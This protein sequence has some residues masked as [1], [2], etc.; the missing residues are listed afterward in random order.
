MSLLKS[1]RFLQTPQLRQQLMLGFL[2]LRI[3]VDA[4]HGAYDD[5]LRFVEVTYAFCAARWVD[6]VDALAHADSLVGTRRLADIA[7][8]AEFVDLQRHVSAASS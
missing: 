1:G 4:F 7:V 6:D 2:E 3:R 5:A 8:D